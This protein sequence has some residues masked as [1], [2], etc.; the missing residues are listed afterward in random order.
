MGGSEE[1]HGLR[2]TQPLLDG[3]TKT[4]A[5]LKVIS[6]YADVVLIKEESDWEGQPKEA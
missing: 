6:P 2:Y 1:L 4:F 3:N 5:A